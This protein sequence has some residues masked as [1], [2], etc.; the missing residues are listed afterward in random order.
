MGVLSDVCG[1][2]PATY[3]GSK[4]VEKGV[5]TEALSAKDIH[6]G[7]NG[8]VSALVANGNINGFGPRALDIAE[9]GG[10]VAETLWFEY[11][12]NPQGPYSA[13][14]GGFLTFFDD[15]GRKKAPGSESYPASAHV[16]PQQAVSG[17]AKY[18]TGA[19]DKTRASLAPPTQLGSGYQF[20]TRWSKVSLEMAIRKGGKVHFHLDGMGDIA[21]TLQKQGQY[22]YSVTS[23]EL[24]Y[25]FRNSKRKAFFNHVILYNGYYKIAG[26]YRPA[27]V[28]P[29]W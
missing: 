17:H 11:R 21:D 15:I 18:K 2:A 13:G 22:N 29:P 23:R 20:G 9:R 10:D 7:V 4:L 16:T 1:F 8:D 3:N 26:K 24:R 27:I 6:F 28:A 19:T 14:L 5:A 12:H 25:V